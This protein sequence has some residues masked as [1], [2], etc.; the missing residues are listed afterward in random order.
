M[1]AP[2]GPTKYYAGVEPGQEFAGFVANDTDTDIFT[3]ETIDK[4][5]FANNK[6]TYLVVSLLDA[7]GNAVFTVE[8]AKIT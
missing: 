8:S 5:L 4:V 6:N 2:I 1:I 3:W 7:E